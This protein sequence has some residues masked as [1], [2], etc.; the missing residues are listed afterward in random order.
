M[1]ADGGQG[2]AVEFMAGRAQPAAALVGR[3]SGRGAGY[4]ASAG[5][6]SYLPDAA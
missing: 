5:L 6:S 2:V 4:L 3:G 1:E